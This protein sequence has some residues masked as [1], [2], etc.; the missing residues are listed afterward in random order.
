MGTWSIQEPYPPKPENHI[1]LYTKQRLQQGLQYI[2]AKRRERV[3][4]PR[5]TTFL[6]IHQSSYEKAIRALKSNKSVVTPITKAQ[7]LDEIH[8]LEALDPKE[9]EAMKK[10]RPH[11]SADKHWTQIATL[12]AVDSNTIEE[13]N[14]VGGSLET[15]A[16]CALYR[17]CSIIGLD[18][19][20][21][22]E[23]IIEYA[24]RNELL[25]HCNKYVEICD[26]GALARAIFQD[27]KEDVQAIFLIVTDPEKPTAWLPT[28]YAISLS[29]ALQKSTEE[30]QA[31]EIRKEKHLLQ[32][33]VGED[34]KKAR[35]IQDEKNRLQ[36]KTNGVKNAKATKD[37]VKPKKGEQP[38]MKEE[39]RRMRALR[40]AAKEAEDESKIKS[41]NLTT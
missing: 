10:I 36:Q 31:R 14:A 4:T 29:K 34:S 32:Q 16:N 39:Y 18:S 27:L 11:F 6:E 35:E 20:H 9:E 40:E 25:S 7:T 21:M 15:N 33:R 38:G 22:R 3:V 23:T 30:K 24:V 19:L 5:T 12:M 26:W 37:E 1:G 17:G 2:R 13:W 41:L 8:S 28:D